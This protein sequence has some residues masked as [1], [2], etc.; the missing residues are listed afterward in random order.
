MASA[1]LIDDDPVRRSA[2]AALLADAGLAIAAPSSPEAEDQPTD[3][4]GALVALAIEHRPHLLA[5]ALDRAGAGP[6]EVVA[7]FHRLRTGIPGDGMALLVIA[8][9]DAGA[10]RVAAALAGGADEVLDPGDLPILAVG[11]VR[12]LVHFRQLAA[13]AILNEQLAQVGRLVAGI[14][15]EIR[16]PL[17]VIRGHAELMALE[18]GPGHPAEARIEPILRNAR[19]LQ[20]R[21]DH[22]MAAVRISPRTAPILDVVPLVR[23]SISLFEKGTDPSRGRVRIDLVVGGPGDEAGA[24]SIPWVRVDPGRLIQVVLNLLS[25][26]H[27]A[28]VAERDSGRVEVR[29]EPS[30]DPD[31]V[32]IEVHDDGPGINARFL[33]RV[34]E[35]FFTTKEG[36]TGYGLYLAAEILREQGGRLTAC[37]PDSGGACF[38]IH[39]PVARAA[40]DAADL[41]GAG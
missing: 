20:V 28:I 22:L 34:F 15:H 10:D 1:L 33:D 5:L 11:R 35:P 39:L 24:G 31:E 4:A 6:A 13:L 37:N 41:S 16:S 9:S 17:T 14:V 38:S 32:R 23:E 8:D 12:R 26:A 25:N 3:P 30:R 21:L 27:E 18:L 36:G 19:T 40:P 29:I 2:V 7:T